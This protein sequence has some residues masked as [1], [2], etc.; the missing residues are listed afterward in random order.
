M[1]PASTWNTDVYLGAAKEVGR[2]R[3]GGPEASSRLP[4]GS[5]V[6]LFGVEPQR[7]PVAGRRM[8]GSAAGQRG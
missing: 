8:T 4:G 5:G 6:G 3:T 2:R 1:E 7:P